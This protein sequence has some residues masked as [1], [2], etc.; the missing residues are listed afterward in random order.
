V[1]PIFPPRLPLRKKLEARHS[2][3][4]PSNVA[5][6]TS[7]L[8]RVSFAAILSAPLTAAAIPTFSKDVLPILQN[9]CQECHRPGEIGPMPLLTYTNVRPWAR[10]IRDSVLTRKMPPWF[11]DPRF[12]HFAND[13]SLSKSEIDTIVNWVDGGAAEGSPKDAPLPRAWPA[14]WSIGTPDAVFEMPDAFAIP[15]QGTIEYQYVILP[16]HFTEDKWIEKVEVRPT[17]R[18]TVH[19]AVVYIREPGSAAW[20]HNQP[21]AKPFS[22][23]ATNHRPNPA[24][25]TT[26]DILMVYTPGN[27]FDSLPR[28]MAK[29]IKAGSD[30]V[31]QMHYT[32]NGKEM[33]DR[34]RIGVVFAKSPP[35]QAVLTLQM[36]NDKFVIPPGDANYRIEV[37]GTLPNEATLISLF[38]HMHLRGKGFEYLLVEPNGKIE[39]LLRVNNY[40]FNWQ[41]NYRLAQ[42]RVLPAGTRLQWIGYFDNSANNPRNPDPKAEVRFGEQSW[43]EMMIGFFDI[44]VDPQIGKPAFFERHH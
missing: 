9:R 41:L 20:L 35:K 18:S 30:I 40:D 26:S 10:A 39:T 34:T 25:L 22:L 29:R 13:R 38:P 37:S 21:I 2:I 14:G 31:L 6:S 24:S 17:D 44:A 43:E 1:G 16:T 28:G 15:A 27:S 12:G 4:V 7:A 33:A 11:A 5:I 8:W 32:A 36:G 3:F 42:P 23:P 19:H